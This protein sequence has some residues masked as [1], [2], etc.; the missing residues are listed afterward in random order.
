MYL[1][2]KLGLVQFLNFYYLTFPSLSIEL[3]SPVFIPLSSVPDQT[4][5][6]I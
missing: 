6:S 4:D 2:F 5:G 1:R 3:F